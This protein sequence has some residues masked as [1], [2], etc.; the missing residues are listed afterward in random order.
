MNYYIKII[1][2]LLIWFLFTSCTW[3]NENQSMIEET[4]EIMNDYVDTLEWSIYDAKDVKALIEANQQNLKNNL[5][6]IY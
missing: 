6:G 2:F 5:D 3:R 4:G 1:L